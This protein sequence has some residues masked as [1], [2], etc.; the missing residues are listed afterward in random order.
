MSKADEVA[1]QLSARVNSSVLISSAI[2]QF[3][4]DYDRFSLVSALIEAGSLVDTD[5]WPAIEGLL[6]DLASVEKVASENPRKYA[7]YSLWMGFVAG[8]WI[9]QAVVFAGLP[10]EV[11]STKRQIQRLARQHAKSKAGTRVLK[12]RTE[13]AQT[14]VP[15]VAGGIMYDI[16]S[17]YYEKRGEVPKKMPSTS[18]LAELVHEHLER[19]AN[20]DSKEKTI[21]LAPSTVARHYLT[22][23]RCQ[24]WW[25]TICKGV[26]AG[27]TRSELGL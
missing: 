26:Q 27:K 19:V 14:T 4:R 13:F 6:D 24:E 10:S 7:R 3:F 5:V 18:E 9:Y 17:D 2:D 1:G 11:E 23:K 22:R 21:R 15:R 25:T 12:E 20:R 16:V 8:L